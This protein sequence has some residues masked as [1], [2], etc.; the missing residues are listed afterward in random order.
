M[1]IQKRSSIITCIDSSHAYT[2]HDENKSHTQFF[3]FVVVAVVIIVVNIFNDDV[4]LHLCIIVLGTHFIRYSKSYKSQRHKSERS[5]RLLKV[6]RFQRI[7]VY[8]M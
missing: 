2:Q 7:F 3:I 6:I 5:F 1:A 4:F 8:L